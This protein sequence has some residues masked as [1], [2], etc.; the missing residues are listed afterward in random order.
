MDYSLYIS[1][2]SVQ[3]R[4]QEEAPLRLWLGARFIYIYILQTVSVNRMG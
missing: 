4:R 3:F 1:G 2:Q